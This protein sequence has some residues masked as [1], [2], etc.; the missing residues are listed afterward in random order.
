[1][2][3]GDQKIRMF[4]IRVIQ[5]SRVK[6]SDEIA[7]RVRERTAFFGHAPNRRENCR[8]RRRVREKPGE[9]KALGHEAKAPPFRDRVAAP[10]VFTCQRRGQGH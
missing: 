9:Q 3:G 5:V 6:L 7:Q 2:L 8:Q 10:F 4:E 1:M